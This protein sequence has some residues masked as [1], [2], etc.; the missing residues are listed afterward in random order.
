MCRALK[1]FNFR[2]S[3]I[4]TASGQLSITGVFLNWILYFYFVKQSKNIK[5]LHSAIGEN[6]VV[7]IQSLKK[8][9]G[10]TLNS[11]SYSTVE[12]PSSADLIQIKSKF[13]D[14]GL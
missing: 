9:E 12:T 5:S 11:M 10:C 8:K 7:F 13:I 2:T 1:E 3:I 6:W 4:Q 14:L